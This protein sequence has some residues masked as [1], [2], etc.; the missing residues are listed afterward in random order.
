VPHPSDRFA[1]EDKAFIVLVIAVSI[2]FLWI[3]W[4]FYGAVLWGAAIAIVFAPLERRL[5]RR[6]GGRKTAAALATLLLIVVMVLVPLGLVGTLLGRQA[7]TVYA[8]LQSG[9]LDFQQLLLRVSDALPGWVMGLLE[10]VGVNNLGDL[11]AR[12]AAG[13][14]AVSQ[15]LAEQVVNVGQMTF[16]IVIGAFVM[17]YLLF[18][19]LRDGDALAARFNDAIP[20]RV[21]QRRAL[22]AKFTA[23]IRAMIKGTLAVAV[24]QGALGGLIFWIL[25]IPAPALWGVVMG[26]LSLL[27]AIG[28]PIV[29]LPVGVYL[30]ASGQ[31][32]QG[33]VLLA[34]GVL[35]ISL[36]D[37]LL[38][39]ILVG[40]DTHIPDYVVLISTLGG[41]AILG[42]NGLLIGPVVAALFIATWDIFAESRRTP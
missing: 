40:K 41:V 5:R 27:P 23:V 30:L 3:I 15:G 4:P 25:G 39:P 26:I 16:S 22:M 14:R 29:W 35:V 21:E 20:L 12:V 8:R 1:L 33:I 10:R 6:M 11:Q 38:R 9:E 32:W 36:V 31:T 34:Y 2:A 13:L 24:A 19:L 37:N 42:V 28:T 7:A 17:L 18:F